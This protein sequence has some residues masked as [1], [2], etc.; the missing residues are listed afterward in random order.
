MPP[1]LRTLLLL[2]LLL[3]VA[4]IGGGKGPKVGDEDRGRVRR[5]WLAFGGA[6]TVAVAFRAATGRRLGR[7]AL[8]AHRMA[9]SPTY[10]HSGGAPPPCFWRQPSVFAW[11]N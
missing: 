3:L 5:L 4:P 11:P 7:S 6:A 8:Y 10:L 9:S 1:P 2:L